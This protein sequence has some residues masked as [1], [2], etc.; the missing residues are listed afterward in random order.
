MLFRST[1]PPNPA[2]G[3]TGAQFAQSIAAAANARTDL[4][5]NGQKLPD[6]IGF[7]AIGEI[8]F[9]WPATGKLV[10]HRLHWQS[11]GPTGLA[12]WVEY[13]VGVDDAALDANG[14]SYKDLTL[15]VAP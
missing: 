8:T 14:Q 2:T 6:C 15:D 1:A 13:D 5:S 12:S 3:A 9:A 10:H 4:I 11:P 7:N